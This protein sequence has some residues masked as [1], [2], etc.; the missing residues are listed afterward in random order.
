MKKEDKDNLAQI[1]EIFKQD[2][3]SDLND[4]V[5]EVLEYLLKKEG[6]LGWLTNPYIQNFEAYIAT[7][8]MKYI[9]S[10]ILSFVG[11]AVTEYRTLGRV[12][13]DIV[14]SGAINKLTY[15][16]TRVGNEY[17]NT[18]SNRLEEINDKVNDLSGVFFQEPL[19]IMKLLNN[20]EAHK[21]EKLSLFSFNLPKFKIPG[22][23]DKLNRNDNNRNKT[24]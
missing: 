16:E 17:Q 7:P 21:L 12:V 14:N 22:K 24:R 5:L 20:E 15:L 4:T 11:E 13:V 18:I 23:G 3:D 2:E 1:F 6:R 8:L 10:D 9:A 19:M